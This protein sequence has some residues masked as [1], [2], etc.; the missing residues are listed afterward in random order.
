MKLFWRRIV[1][2]SFILAFFIIAPLLLFYTAGYR[3]NLKKMEVEKTGIMVLETDPEGAE[4]YIDNKKFEEYTPIQINNIFPN[5]YFIQLQK[6]GFH[7]WQKNLDIENN[8]TTFAKGIILF[9]KSL[10]I[11]KMSGDISDIYLLPQKDKIIYLQQTKGVK[12]IKLWDIK[13]ESDLDIYQLVDEE[14]SFDDLIKSTEENK[15]VIPVTGAQKE[16]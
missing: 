12:K 13:T 7:S 10:P 8:S 6:E 1:Y 14:V 2:M 9:K 3:I 4:I 15:I 5:T 11:L 16:F